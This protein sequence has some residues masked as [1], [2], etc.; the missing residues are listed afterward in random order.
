MRA[1]YAIIIEQP[2]NFKELLA[3]FNATVLE[4]KDTIKNTDLKII[5]KTLFQ[6][7]LIQLNFESIQTSFI[8]TNEKYVSE[9]SKPENSEYKTLFESLKLNIEPRYKDSLSSVYDS[10]GVVAFTEASN[11]NIHV[12][13]PINLEPEQQKPTLDDIFKEYIKSSTRDSTLRVIK[14]LKLITSS[15][16]HDGES[17]TTALCEML[18]N[19]NYAPEM[20]NIESSQ[21]KNFIQMIEGAVTNFYQS[22]FGSSKYLGLFNWNI[23]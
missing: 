13:F 21:S 7:A 17:F 11:Q 2:T 12:K 23:T 1:R 3:A 15:I 5:R 14:D 18:T 10:M 22:H 4:G 9:M 6:G 8:L 19:T 20:A 16:T